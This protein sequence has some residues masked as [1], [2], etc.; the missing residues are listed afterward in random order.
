M[1]S[2]GESILYIP[3]STT[4]ICKSIHNVALDAAD[5]AS[6]LKSCCFSHLGTPCKSLHKV[7]VL[8]FDWFPAFCD[9]LPWIPA[10]APGEGLFQMLFVNHASAPFAAYWGADVSNDSPSLLKYI[11]HPLCYTWTQTWGSTELTML[12]FE[13]HSADV[14][15]WGS[16][17]REVMYHHID[18]SHRLL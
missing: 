18:E 16:P 9:T 11:R 1:L 12:T 10:K 2:M 4:Y 14:G 3:H 5:T 17:K 7:R 6:C 15:S 13:I 8:L